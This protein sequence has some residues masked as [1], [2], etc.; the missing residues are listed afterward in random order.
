MTLTEGV[1]STATSLDANSA[2]L[3]GRVINLS[4]DKCVY[5]YV[6]N[7]GSGFVRARVVT[8]SGDTI[9]AIGSETIVS[10][11]MGDT[12]SVAALSSSSFVVVGRDAN[13]AVAALGAIL[14][15]ACTV[16]G[17]TI[18]AGADTA[19]ESAG[20]TVI[21]R[22]EVNVG[23]VDT[24]KAV[25]TYTDRNNSLFGTARA[26]TVTGTT[27][28]TPGSAHVF[29]SGTTQYHWVDEFPG[30]GGTECIAAYL[31]G[32]DVVVQNLSVSGTTVSS[33]TA[34]SIATT[35][36][37]V[38]IMCIGMTSTDALVAYEQNSG[39]ADFGHI[40]HITRSGSTL[41]DAGSQGYGSD[42][43]ATI[44]HGLT[45]MSDTIALFT[46]MATDEFA[47]EVDISGAIALGTALNI[48]SPGANDNVGIALSATNRAVSIHNITDIA[49]ITTDLIPTTVALLDIAPMR[50]PASINA[51]GTHIFLAALNNSGF[52]VLVKILANLSADGDL[53]FSPSAGDN[54]GV[55]CGKYD[56]DIVWV[57]GNF[58]GTD[59]VEK[60][61][62][63]GTSFVVKDNGSFDPV[64]SFIV[65]PDSDDRV[66]IF[67]DAGGSVPS[68]SI[69]ET[70]DNGDSWEERNST[71][72]LIS[73]AVVRLDINVEE[74]VTGNEASATDN[75]DYSINSGA[76]LEDYSSGFPQVDVT[77]V[78]VG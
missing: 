66:L 31:G 11:D 51:D 49:V 24:N 1:N 73:K 45:R 32:G 25:V 23:K 63:G 74:L 12:F 58:G 38:E 68:T 61:E 37:Y 53:V 4:A 76:D 2:C 70:D 29:N 59:T 54:I 67:T 17:S 3:Y 75:I 35:A 36:T 78:V 56:A 16:V 9:S 62:D 46:Y 13:G 47:Q 20:G 26:F 28:N 40:H 64:T 44:I 21:T 41:T 52:P 14:G 15:V 22:Q 18:T 5:V 48:A 8:V 19:I 43:T 69:Q 55:Q 34:L 50:K 27:I 42:T 10:E 71:L 30:S 57:A 65:G 60:S 33:G 77:G 39:I 7:A 72:S 6:D